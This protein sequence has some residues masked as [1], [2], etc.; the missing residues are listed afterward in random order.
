[1]AA[2]RPRSAFTLNLISSPRLCPSDSHSTGT[3]VH[4]AEHH[5]SCTGVR[6]G[7]PL[8]FSSTTTN[9]AGSVLLALRPTT[10]TSNWLRVLD[11][12]E[13]SQIDQHIR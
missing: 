1:V 5:W 6:M 3:R 13:R 2:L 4:G 9:L 12:A 10:C 8:A 11:T 7:A